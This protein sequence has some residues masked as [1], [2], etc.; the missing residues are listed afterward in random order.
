M[1]E[2]HAFR[3]LR[4]ASSVVKDLGSATCPPYDVMDAAAQKAFHELSP[5]NAVRLELGYDADGDTADE[6][7]YTRAA[8]TL[9]SWRSAGVLRR[10]G[11]PCLYRYAQ[12]FRDAR[13][14]ERTRT[15]MLVLLRLEEFAAGIVLPHE[16]TFPHHKED[17][18]RLLAA[19]RAQISPILGLFRSPDPSL[20]ARLRD[21]EGDAPGASPGTEGPR[22]PGIDFRD[23]EGVRHRLWPLADPGLH[24]AY[25]ND[26]R[27]CQ[28]FIADGHHRYETAL[29]YRAEQRRKQP[30][31]PDDWFDYVMI[32]LVEMSDPGLVVYPTHRILEAP[33]VD[34]E[35][36]LARLQ[37]V[38]Q[39]ERLP[40]PE[41]EDAALAAVEGRLRRHTLALLIPPA[42]EAALLTLSGTRAM[43]QAAGEHSPAWRDLDVAILHRLAL[44]A[45]QASAAGELRVQYTRDGGEALRAARGG[46]AAFLM[47]PATVDDLRA[48]SS[49]GERM[50]EKSTYFFP[51][52]RTGLVFYD[53]L[54]GPIPETEAI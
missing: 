45:V 34:G 52:A 41:A 16:E 12:S 37:A 54:G 24:A 51:K 46:A 15:G 2:V 29:R 23:E 7:R 14:E 20:H 40:L 6:N 17:R 19:C 22:A 10:D 21:V 11:P 27:G 5:Y 42:R 18:Y 31:A 39:V 1:A 26:L 53:E 35:G 3:G 50:P 38:F 48:V 28:V 36:A 30:D 25:A 47:A 13:G 9:A 32:L 4:F 49:S 8:G 44:P 43:E 33:S